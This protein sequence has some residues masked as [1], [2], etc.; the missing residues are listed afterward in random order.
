MQRYAQTWTKLL[1]FYNDFAEFEKKIHQQSITQDEVTEF[2]EKVRNDLANFQVSA[3][4]YYSPAIVDMLL[5]PIL[6]FMDE[7]GK[8]LLEPEGLLWYSLYKEFYDRHDA[9]EL[10]F[11]LI[12]NVLH[13]QQFPCEVYAGLWLLLEQGFLGR[14]YD[15]ARS[16]I[17]FYRKQLRLIVLQ[18][19]QQQNFD[20]EFLLEPIKNNK[21]TKFSKFA[22][23]FYLL[24]PNLHLTILSIVAPLGIYCYSIFSGI[25]SWTN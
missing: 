25:L 9:G 10:I 16:K 7:N 2:R 6:A 23:A 15:H 24:K 4:N 1:S 19:A 8:I 11:E 17:G 12:E 14:Y 20:Q 3:L 22:K 5:Q 18:Q 21:D 13:N